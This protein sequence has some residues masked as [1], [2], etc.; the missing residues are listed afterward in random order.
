M[1]W[2]S[3]VSAACLALCLS[4]CHKIEPVTQ[5]EHIIVTELTAR[6]KSRCVGRFLIDMPADALSAGRTEVQGVRVEARKMPQEEY[7]TAMDVLS[8]K[9][10]AT[11]STKGF[12]F[13][14]A[15]GEIEGIKGSRYFISLGKPYASTDSERL[16]EAYKWDQGYQ[17]KLQISASDAKNSTYFKNMPSVRDDPD[18]TDIPE[19]TQRVV[20]M[21]SLIRGR[22]D[23]DIPTEPGVC[24]MGGFLPGK[25]TAQETI[26]ASFLLHD[27]HDV[28]FRVDTDSDIHE[29]DTLLQR[30]EMNAAIKASGGRTIRKAEIELR[31]IQQ[32]EEWLSDGL[33]G[34]QVR[35]HHFV[36]EANSKIGSA[37][38]PMVSLN[39]DNGGRLPGIDGDRQL[40]QAS[41]TEGEAVALWDA[42]SRSLHPRPNAF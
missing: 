9:L 3:R 32:A 23:D 7:R 30:T 24:F 20:S 19:R 14:Y 1:N 15:D 34:A 18:M 16:I 35:G 36:L 31:G 28:G 21:L 41:L 17:I 4:A 33:T 25:A 2:T 37:T 42:V 40:T 26:S 38:S 6:L 27:M 39:M 5:Q 10:I 29:S 12:R 22:E 13:V 8:K 11:K